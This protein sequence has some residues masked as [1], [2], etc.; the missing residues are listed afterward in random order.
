[1]KPLLLAGI[2]IASAAAQT[3]LT[4]RP[5]VIHHFEG[6]IELNGYKLTADLPIFHIMGDRSLLRSADGR[7]EVLLNPCTQLR[8]GD[9]SA[10]RMVS[11]S[12]TAARVE[13][14]AGSAVLQLDGGPKSGSVEMNLGGN[15]IQLARAGIYRFDAEP[16]R[17]RVFNGQA[18]VPGVGKL[19]TGHALSIG[20]AIGRFDLKTLDA[21]QEWNDLRTRQLMDE[22]GLTGAFGRP[23]VC[24]P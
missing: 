16:P 17:L 15:T 21:L 19:S 6:E 14:M 12:L 2:L 8:L 24:V 10:L 7:A 9:R 1:M 3:L 11:N 5:G 13:L 18:A 4:A 22:G 20:G 23:R